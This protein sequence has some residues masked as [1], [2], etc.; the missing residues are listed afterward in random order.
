[1]AL[2]ELGI[3]KL[4]AP[5]AGKRREKYDREIRGFGI[6]ITDR[7]IRSYILLYSFGGR[8]RRYTLGRVGEL[9]IDEAR[10]EARRLRGLIRQGH[11]PAAE[12]KAA[13]AAV[14]IAATPKTFGE[15]VDLYE[16]R[17]LGSK[18]RG[19]QTR[20]TIDLHLM[21]SWRD[22]PLTSITR[23]HV[24][25]R[26]EVLVDAQKQEMARGV[27]QICRR[28]FN[29]AISRGTFGIEH[30]P[31]E[32]LRPADVIG[33]RSIRQRVLTNVEWRA[34]FAALP[35]LGSPAQP[36]V[37]LLAL[38]GLRLREV[39][40]GRFSELDLAAKTWTLPPERTKAGVTHIVPLTPGMLRILGAIPRKDGVKFLFPGPHANRPFTTFSR[41]KKTIDQQ[42]AEEIRRELKDPK[43]ELVPFRLHDLRRSMRTGLSELPVPGGDLVRELI[44][45]HAR[46]GL[47][48][49]YDQAAYLSEKRRGLELWG[50]RLAAILENRQADVIDLNLTQRA[51]ESR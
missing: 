32:K 34:L 28:L 1:M 10:E 7:G 22:I 4:K 41:L 14:K 36:M 30:S 47:H 8:R 40:E 3:R 45:G 20:M 24:L 26:V 17:V 38:T 37:T 13:R 43:A 46:P 25:E 16:K 39:A 19:R 15:V 18:R 5:K 51:S 49:V 23:A 31:C 42:M 21:P 6:R 44:I 48:Q 11:D 33:K 50:E 35:K 9:A 12:E 29:W 27:F 2:T